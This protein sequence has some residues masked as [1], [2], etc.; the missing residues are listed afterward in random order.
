[1]STD[2]PFKDNQIFTEEMA[3]AARE[4]LRDKL[5]KMDGEVPNGLAASD[6]E[7]QMIDPDDEDEQPSIDDLLPFTLAE[8]DLID[9]L[10]ATVRQRMVSADPE[11]L[12]KIAAFLYALERLP[13]ATP[14]VSLDLAIMGRGDENLSYTSVEMDGQSFR[15]S[16]GGSVY[17]PDVGSDSFSETTFEIEA[18]GFRD[19]STEAFSD[20]LDAFV[21][22]KGA[23]EIQGDDDADLTEPA[24]NDGWDRLAKY[25]DTHGEEA[26]G[27]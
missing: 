20:W 27:W 7:V 17:S 25:W 13:Y 24:P 11:S 15:L 18:G 4:R 23:I 3:N 22:A 5:S 14:D 21:S 26:D 6:A 19:G 16:T 2:R 12:K 1:M 9:Q 8:Q 10:G